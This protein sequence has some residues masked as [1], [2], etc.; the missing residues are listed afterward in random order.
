MIAPT[1][2]NAAAVTL[3]AVKMEKTGKI[4]A[5][6]KNNNAVTVAD[7]PVLAPIE[8]PTLLSANDVTVLV[9]S[10]AQIKAPVASART[11]LR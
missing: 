9:P 10:G 3:P 11:A 5:L 7:K 6:I 4:K 2:T 1:V 8:T